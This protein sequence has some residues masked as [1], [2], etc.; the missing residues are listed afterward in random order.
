MEARYSQSIDS[1]NMAI[2]TFSAGFISKNNS[3]KSI[4]LCFLR[5]LMIWLP[6]KYRLF[7]GLMS[8]GSSIYVALWILKNST[9][10]ERVG[11][12]NIYTKLELFKGHGYI[13]VAGLYSA[14]HV[15]NYFEK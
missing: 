1:A 5:D 7:F 4:S 9:P 14:N 15:L 11:G 6:L 10:D 8:L 13:V 3:I 2:E 12:Q